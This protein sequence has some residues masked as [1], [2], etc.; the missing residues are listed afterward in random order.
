MSRAQ[1]ETID[2]SELNIVEESLVTAL[3]RATE[4]TAWKAAHAALKE[5]A[6]RWDG[7]AVQRQ[8]LDVNRNVEEQRKIHL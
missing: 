2:L 6:D 8:Q 7:K 1:L 3:L 4:A 5:V